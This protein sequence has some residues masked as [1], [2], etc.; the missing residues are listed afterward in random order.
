MS[1]NKTI[2]LNNK[3]YQ[4]Y[5]NNCGGAEYVQ[6]YR[7]TISNTILTKKDDRYYSKKMDE[8]RTCEWAN[9]QKFEVFGKFQE[10]KNRVNF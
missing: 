8:A 1:T 10:I 3:S 9:F 2:L 4:V 5:Y 6:F 7:D